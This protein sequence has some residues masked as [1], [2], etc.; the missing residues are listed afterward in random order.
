MVSLLTN[1]KVEGKSYF[2]SE[3]N[4][5]VLDVDSIEQI[6]YL[7]LSMAQHVE[8]AVATAMNGL[9]ELKN[10]LALAV[11]DSDKVINSYEIDLDNATHKYLAL[12]KP[13]ESDLRTILA[14]QS[15]TINLERIGDHAVNIAESTLHL[16]RNL[17]KRNFFELPKMSGFVQKM[18]RDANA[19]FFDNNHH[20]AQDILSRDDEIDLITS[21]IINMIKERV[22]SGK[23]SFDN[24][25]EFILI[26]KNLERI[27]DLSTNIAE[28]VMY[29][30]TSTNVKHR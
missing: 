6:R 21:N 16:N 15:I 18:L 7:L 26:S 10:E 5:K 13:S 20:L 19:S 12:R 3:L 4:K 14:I 8:N 27:A 25:L 28:Q 2:I 1:Q 30:A 9:L 29:N 22:L 11:I 17:I 23:E 24:A